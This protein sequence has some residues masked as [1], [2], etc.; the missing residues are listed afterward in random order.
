MLMLEANLDLA[1]RLGKEAR[2]YVV[3][4]HSLEQFE[5]MWVE[6]LELAVKRYEGGPTKP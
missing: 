6:I 1:L 3:E 2:R 4:N 5:K